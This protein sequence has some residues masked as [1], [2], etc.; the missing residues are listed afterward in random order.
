M[1]WANAIRYLCCATFVL[2][3]TGCNRPSS[4][5]N[6]ATKSGEDAIVLARI[7]GETIT[8]TEFEAE[9]KRRAAGHPQILA[10]REQHRKVLEEMVRFRVVLAAAKAAGYDRDPEVQ[11]KVNQFIVSSFQES[12]L[13]G[14]PASP[15]P[16]DAALRDF[17]Q[18]RLPEFATPAAVRAAVIYFKCSPKATAAKQAE[19]KQQA[20]SVL[21]R[22]QDL[23][24]AG[25]RQLVQE[26][27]EDVATRYVGGDTGWL[28]SAQ[29]AHRWAA[30]VIDAA[31]SISEPG[32]LAPLV[33]SPDGFYVVR[34]T[35]RRPAGV[36]PF[37]QVKDAIAYQVTRLRR[38]QRER[39]VFE[40]MKLGIKVE[41]YPELLD[42]TPAAKQASEPKPV[43]LPQG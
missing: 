8:L 9:L 26:Y 27:S 7:G 3:L 22:A 13:A 38:E 34:L 14:H 4:T 36:R 30:G 6:S 39:D 1:Y 16:P 41:I 11:A 37:D 17:Y 23:D 10:T 24:E 5:P 19:L 40:E 32:Q 21:T 35:G 2:G 42:V 18:Q 15:A 29:A 20:E 43:P 33:Q 25:F 12:K 28:T 31:F